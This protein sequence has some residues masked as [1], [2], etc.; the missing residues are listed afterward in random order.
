MKPVWLRVVIYDSALSL[1]ARR[2]S[3]R[4]HWLRGDDLRAVIDSSES[5]SAQSLTKQNQEGNSS[6]RSHW[7]RGDDLRAVI[8]SSESISAQSLTA[9]SP[10]PRSHWLRGVNYNFEY[11]GEYESIWKIVLVWKLGTH[12]ELI[13][14]K[15]R[16]SKISWHCPF[17]GRERWLKFS[18]VSAYYI[19]CLQIA[20]LCGHCACTLQ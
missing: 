1:T 5:I 9:P 2:S 10:S 17:K 18:T 16:G 14:E 12:M 8:D 15:K 20:V 4:S 7:L 19:L 6:P 11:L 3:P 13:H